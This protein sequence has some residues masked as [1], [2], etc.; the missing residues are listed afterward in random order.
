MRSCGRL[1]VSFPTVCDLRVDPAPPQPD[2]PLIMSLL[3]TL[4]H[5]WLLPRL[6]V[7]TPL[8]VG[9]CVPMLQM[10]TLRGKEV[11]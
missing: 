2:K 6:I 8:K 9:G 1:W 7:T 11:K 3:Q 10:R 4:G 5:L